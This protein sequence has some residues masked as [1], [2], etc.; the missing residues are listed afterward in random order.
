[1][2]EAAGEQVDGGGAHV[3][4]SAPEVR[5]AWPDN[6]RSQIAGS[7]EK[8]AKQLE[9]YASPAD[10]WKKARAL[11]QRLSSGELR[12][13]LPKE[14]TAEQVSVWRRENGIPEKP[15]DYDVKV[16]G[17]EW[18][19]DR[20]AALDRLTQKM[21]A[22]AVS[23]AHVKAVAEWAASERDLAMKAVEQTD[24]SKIRETTDLLRAEWGTEYTR[25]ENLMKSLLDMGPPG[26]RDK[27]AHGRTGDGLPLAADP[28]YLRW[29]TMV[30]LQ[31]NPQPTLTGSGDTTGQ[32]VDD[33]IGAIEKEMR[34]RGSEYYKGQIDPATGD[35][36][37]ASE[38]RRLVEWRERQR[39]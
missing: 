37:M 5:P 2:D 34:N 10:I 32:S 25:N 11:E 20:K 39:K 12:A 1:M 14:A 30:A 13:T 17:V 33:R 9:R 15:E 28:D 19:A 16:E 3:V 4:T 36:K 31:V 7:D 8:E 35:T 6:W 22:Q 23:P 26:L 38:Y 21:H 24:A 18:D 27:I 29:L